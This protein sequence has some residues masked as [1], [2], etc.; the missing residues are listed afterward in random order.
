MDPVFGGGVMK[1]ECLFPKIRCVSMFDSIFPIDTLLKC[2][3]SR[4]DLFCTIAFAT[5]GCGAVAF[6]RVRAGRP[7]LDGPYR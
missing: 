3:D 7:D 6:E 5:Q 2:I 4:L 1:R